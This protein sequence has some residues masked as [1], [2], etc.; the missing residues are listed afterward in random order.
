[1]DYPWFVAPR[2]QMGGHLISKTP[3]QHQHTHKN[4]DVIKM[5]S[6]GYIWF[7]FFNVKSR[8]N[9]K[10]L[11]SDSSPQWSFEELQLSTFCQIWGIFKTKI[12]WNVKISAIKINA[13]P[14]KCV[15]YLS[16]VFLLTFQPLIGTNGL[17]MWFRS[18]ADS[19]LLFQHAK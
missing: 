18:T 12:I 11:V 2:L 17:I 10:L 4:T 19:T 5:L 14:N 1:M 9:N 15:Y 7:Y 8:V 13:S 6:S 3:H 16:S